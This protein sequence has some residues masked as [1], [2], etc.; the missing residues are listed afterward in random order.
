MASAMDVGMPEEEDKMAES[1]H[2]GNHAGRTSVAVIGEDVTSADVEGWSSAGGKIK[3]SKTGEKDGAENINTPGQRARSKERAKFAKRVAA[4]T[5]RAARMPTTMPKE[6]HTIIMRPRGG[7]NVARTEASVIM[8]IVTTAARV[9]TEEAKEDTICV[10]ATQNIIIIGTSDD[11]RCKLYAGVRALVIGGKTHEVHAYR[12]AP[13]GHVKGVIRGIAVEDTPAQIRDNIVNKYN[14]LAVEAHRIANTTTVIVLFEGEKV[15]NYVK[16]GS[17]LIKCGL[18]RKH[19]EVCRQCGK[20]GHRSDVCPFPNTRVCYDCG[21]ANPKE[22]HEKECKPKC[23]LCGGQHPTAARECTNKYKMPYVVKKRQWERKNEASLAR[24]QQL[25]ALGK[26]NFPPLQP[27]PTTTTATTETPRGRS[28]QR[29]GSRHRSTSQRAS[30]IGQ[31]R[32]SQSRERVAWADT[33]KATK[34]P[35]NQKPEESEA[36]KALKAENEKLKKKINE[37]DSKITEQGNI[38]KEMS[39]KLDQLISLQQQQQARKETEETMEDEPVPEVDPRTCRA[40]E[41]AAK[42]KAI[43]K[44]EIRRLAARQER[45]EEKCN[46]RFTNLETAVHNIQVAIGQIQAQLQMIM[47]IIR[48]SAGN[49]NGTTIQ[50][51]QWIGQTGQPQPQ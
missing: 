32:P 17:I 51:Q 48:P 21:A 19:Y 14:P 45:F 1:I 42:R 12:S 40:S 9:T 33:V 28:R 30:N 22:G 27:E 46:E 35:V 13:D 7:L 20:I 11:R 3:S 15:P 4:A 16:Y 38:I 47:E 34:T 26:D 44:S 41:P 10:N 36:M 37:Q 6:D 25:Q 29:D 49:Q 39:E 31:R 2:V 43:E 24:Q 8:S 50:Q 18:Y 23:K 5:T